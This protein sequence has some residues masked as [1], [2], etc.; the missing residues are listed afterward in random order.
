MVNHPLNDED[1][2]QPYSDED[3]QPNIRDL[4]YFRNN[5][6]ADAGPGN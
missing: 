5:I 4:Q 1:A 2:E 6:D 3:N